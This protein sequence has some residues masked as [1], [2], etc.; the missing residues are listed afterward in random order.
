[1]R[2]LISQEKKN[3]RLAMLLVALISAGALAFWLAGPNESSPI[4]KDI[5]QITDYT[6]ITKVVLKSATANVELAFNGTRWQVNDRY[7]ADRD[8]IS[9]LFATL[10]EARPKRRL[11]ASLVDSVNL[12]IEK[13]GVEVSLFNG[14]ALEKRFTAGGNALKTQSFFKDLNTDNTFVVTIP[15]YRVYVSGIFE[16]T[17]NQWRDKYVFGFNWRNFER[18]EV[19]FP[20]RPDDNFVV[21][22]QNNVFSVVGIKTDTTK[23]GRYMDN[24][25]RLTVNEYLD[26]SAFTDSLIGSKPRMVMTISD[27]AKNQYSLRVFDLT[28]GQVPGLVHESQ[29]AMFNRLKIQAILKPKSFFQQ[30]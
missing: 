29:G 6:K 9:V 7:P 30:K 27:I 3:K 28:S 11:P 13:E 24:V 17:E 12:Q 5:F 18:L 1:M 20:H 19:S 23:L 26:R 21:A 16:L 14:E 10:K 8:L 25:L 4:D 15:G 2:A 22:P